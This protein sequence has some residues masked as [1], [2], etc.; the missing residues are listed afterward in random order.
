MTRS[1]DRDELGEVMREL[2]RLRHRHAAA[3]KRRERLLERV[4]WFP[5]EVNTR[6]LQALDAEQREMEARMRDLQARVDAESG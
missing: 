1:D 3:T 4:S 2:G 5:N 6:D